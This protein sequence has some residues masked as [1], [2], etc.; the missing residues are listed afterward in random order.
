M[1]TRVSILIPCYNAAA[2]LVE[3][4]D[5]ALAQTW[6]DREIIVC[7][8]GSRDDSAA[9]VERYR[10]R[11]VHLLRQ[12]NA[13]AAAARNRAFAASTGAFV[14][15]L[16]ADDVLAPDKLAQQMQRA[17]AQ[18]DGNTWIYSGA[19]ARFFHHPQD[20]TPAPDG[21]W[22]DLTP[23]DWLTLALRDAVMMHPA[24]WLTPRGLIERAGAW[25]EDLSLNDDGE[26]FA[27][28]VAA[29]SGVAFVAAARSYYRSGDVR[30]L[31]GA[32]GARAWN[33]AWQAL[34]GM[35]AALRA[36]RDDDATSRAYAHACARLAFEAYPYS[37]DVYAAAR[38]AAGEVATPASAAP[39]TRSFTWAARLLGWRGARWLQARL[40]DLGY[41]RLGF[42]R[43]KRGVSV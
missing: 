13:G 37:H 32:R 11:G 10:S 12:A 6:R 2:T 7:D 20:A 23:T 34:Q 35:G 25:R 16:D 38:A 17:L 3:T 42:W 4:L 21:L 36:L 22:R 24:A 18:Q 19:W 39:R 28:V 31:S 30:T 41:Q 1:N 33:S 9:I 40:Y 43:R 5:S 26:F 8:D 29:S 27:R 15:Y 14:Q